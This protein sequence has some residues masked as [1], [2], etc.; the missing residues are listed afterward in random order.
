VLVG[1]RNDRP[2]LAAANAECGAFF[3]PPST[4]MSINDPIALAPIPCNALGPGVDAH[5]L[6]NVTS[7][8][9]VIA[10]DA[11]ATVVVARNDPA[12]GTDVSLWT[13]AL[14]NGAPVFTNPIDLA[15]SPN[16]I[17]A[18]VGATP[19]GTA[20][21]CVDAAQAELGSKTVGSITYGSGADLVVA[22]HVPHLDPR[23]QALVTTIQLFA[24]LED[25]NG[26]AP[27]Y[28]L[29]VDEGRDFVPNLRIGDFNGDGLDD[30]VFTAGTAGQG[31]V[32]VRL[33]CD[34]HDT[35]CKA[36]GGP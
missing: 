14:D 22:C 12:T 9:I 27:F 24:R 13:L 34:S 31:N 28:Q 8:R 21:T 26:G 20:V 29:L 11:A 3:D 1:L 30:V 17:A 7:I 2:D 35:T 25:P 5:A 4:N 6:V 32:H 19:A 10:T 16:E 23:S 18:F 15:S 33:Q 36:P